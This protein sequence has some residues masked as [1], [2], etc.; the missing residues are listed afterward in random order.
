[1]ES[2]LDDDERQEGNRR[3]GRTRKTVQTSSGPVELE[4][5]R[6][7]NGTFEPD[8]IKKRETVLVLADTLASKIVGMYELGM[9]F[10]DI[11]SHLK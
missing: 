3:N 2:H 1:M 9:S 8:L 7:R 10:R 4:T 5:S 6:D 11:S